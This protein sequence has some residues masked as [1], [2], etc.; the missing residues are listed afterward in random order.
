MSEAT[1]NV[2]PDTEKNDQ[3]AHSNKK[4]KISETNNDTAMTD[5]M[6]DPDQVEPPKDTDQGRKISFKKAVSNK[7]HT[8]APSTPVVD[9][10]YVSDDDV[11]DGE[12]DKEC[13]TVRVM[14]EEKRRLRKCWSKAVII[15]LLGHTVG[16]NFLIRKL[17]A[18]WQV[19]STM[20]VIDVGNDV[21]VVRFA[22]SDEMERALY[23]G[24]WIIADHYLAVRQWRHNFDPYKF[25]VNRLS[26]WVRFPDLPM[27][28]FDE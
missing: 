17:K 8:T 25:S 19:R 27:E 1:E 10:F 23:E 26:V 16:Y 20:D 11:D 28:F 2:S 4:V 18:L 21:Y 24:P 14:A 3:K 22:N 5:R 6:R 13:P 7:T 9:E 12:D 15:K